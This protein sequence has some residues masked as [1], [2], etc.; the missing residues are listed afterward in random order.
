MGSCIGTSVRVWRK[1]SSPKRARTLR[2]SRKITRRSASRRRKGRVRRRA[3]V[4]NSEQSRQA[5]KGLCSERPW[6]ERLERGSEQGGPLPFFLWCY[7][8]FNGGSQF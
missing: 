7:V 3:T 4:T 6:R 8:L 1:E 5:A 2:H